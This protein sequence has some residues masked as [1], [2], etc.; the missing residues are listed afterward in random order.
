MPIFD[1]RCCECGHQFDLMISYA[2]RDKV[3]CPQCGAANPSQL[4]SPFNTAR[5]VSGVRKPV[6]ESCNGCAAAG[7]G[8]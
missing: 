3:R 4:L 5:P 8:G 6:T 1:F 7:S 2:E